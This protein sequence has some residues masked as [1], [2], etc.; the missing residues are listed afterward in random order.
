MLAR[1]RHC[2]PL[3][4][5]SLL[6]LAPLPVAIA[7]EAGPAS[8]GTGAKPSGNPPEIELTPAEKAEKQSRRACK[9]DI[10]SAMHDK[11]TSGGGISCNIVKSWRKEQLTKLVAKLK[12]TWPYGPVRC[13]SK[14]SLDR[15]ELVKA[16]SEDKA[17]L[18]LKMHSVTCTV[19]RENKPSAELSFEFSPKVSFENGEAVTAQMNWG[20]IAAPTLLKS[21]LWTA[22][23]ADNKINLLSA[24]LV[25][26]INNFIAKK[27][28]AVDGSE[29]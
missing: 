22:T 4:L 27:C 16:V 10:C 20:K 9:V 7:G 21:A 18:Q 25:E 12:V 3:A 17:D 24:T 13:T 8:S 2:L 26:D 1:G 28:P 23:A 5:L 29:K 15:A 6:V 11:Q 19:E 14:V